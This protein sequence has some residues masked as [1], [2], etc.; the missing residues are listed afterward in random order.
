MYKFFKFFL[1][2]FV[3]NPCITRSS[4]RETNTAAHI[5]CHNFNTFVM[6]AVNDFDLYVGFDKTPDTQESIANKRRPYSA[7]YNGQDITGHIYTR[8]IYRYVKQLYFI[9]EKTGTPVSLSYAKIESFFDK[10]GAKH[11]K[12]VF[13]ESTPTSSLK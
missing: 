7:G 12:V 9:Q 8:K 5:V 13:L 4:E 1:L 11:K 6:F 2:V 3:I 10:I